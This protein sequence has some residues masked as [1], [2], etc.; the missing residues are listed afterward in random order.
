MRQKKEPKKKERND[1]LWFTAIV[2][3]MVYVILMDSMSGSREKAC[4]SRLREQLQV[5]SEENG[6]EQ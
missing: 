6:S 5:I 4:T 1:S 3:I 2:L